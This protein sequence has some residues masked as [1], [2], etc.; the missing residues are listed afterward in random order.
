MKDT[1]YNE[2][3]KTGRQLPEK[4]QAEIVAERASKGKSYEQMLK[5][6]RDSM[7]EKKM[8]KTPPI[9]LPD[10]GSIPPDVSMSE[11]SKKMI[12]DTNAGYEYTKK[13]PFKSGGSVK[14]SA[15]KRADG[16]AV[17]GKTKGRML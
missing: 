5:E 1:P 11:E 3:T 2:M 7:V 16:C 12:D 13:K 4:T 17:R 10:V 9:P 6:A 8:G 14:S 15:S